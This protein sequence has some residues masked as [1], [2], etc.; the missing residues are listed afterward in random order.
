MRALTWQGNE[1]VS[2]EDGAR[3]SD[4]G[5]DRR[6]H[7]GDLDRHLRVGPAPLRGARSVPEA[8]RRPGS[9]GHG[10]RR[11][12]RSGRRRP[13]PGDRV[14]V[15]FNISCGHCWMCSRG[16]FAQCETTQV[17]DDRQGRDACSGTPRCTAR[18]RAVRPS[19]CACP[20]PSSARSRCPTGRPTSSSSTSPTSCRRRG[21]RCSTPT[22]R[23]AAPSRS[24]ARGRSGRSP[25]RI[26][27]HLGAGR[28]IGV[29]LVPER[30]SWP[31]SYGAETIDLR[32]VDDV[33]AAL[34]DLV[35]GRGPD[36]V[37]DAVGMEAHG[38][39]LAQAAPRPRSGCCPRPWPKP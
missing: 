37:I 8:R 10:H 36:A 34:I 25:S 24:S 9:R 12:G 15:P 32:H 7:P 23:R 26:A 20:R 17:R 29:D 4:R 31:G 2:V 39:R 35:D 22:C 30:L 6:D 21:R 38:R 27:L 13:T 14:V 3:P 18:C 19:T 11:G 5:A 33:A 1:D 16:L 28:V